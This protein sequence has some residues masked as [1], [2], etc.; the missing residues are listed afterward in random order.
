MPSK[1]S[2]RRKTAKA[3]KKRALSLSKKRGGSLRRSAGASEKA[4]VALKGVK[5]AAKKKG[6]PAAFAALVPDPT[7]PN[8]DKIE[9]IVVLMMENRS[10]DHVLGYLTLELGR[11]DVDGLTKDLRNTYQGKDYFP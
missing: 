5:V 3:S 8:L 6:S 4:G 7:L 9:H 1:N 11:T 2:K 10:F